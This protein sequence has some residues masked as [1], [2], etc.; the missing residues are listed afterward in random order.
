MITYKK[1]RL[2]TRLG[3]ERWNSLTLDDGRVYKPA[4]FEFEKGFVAI[5]SKAGCTSIKLAWLRHKGFVGLNE[6]PTLRKIH[7][8]ALIKNR[9]SFEDAEKSDK[10]I[11]YIV[12]DPANRYASVW[13][14]YNDAPL[15]YIPRGFNVNELLVWASQENVFNT[16]FHLLPQT[17]G[18]HKF[19]DLLPMTKDGMNLLGDLLGCDM[20]HIHKSKEG[21][22]PKLSETQLGFIKKMYKADYE[23]YEKAKQNYLTHVNTSTT[24]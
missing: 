4:V 19:M 9:S 20:P 15:T 1:N 17:I 16:D 18:Y 7:R 14:M 10:P 5:V 12:N 13:R 21:S 3:L 8:F 24:E 2:C 22:K 11:Y 6:T 23:L